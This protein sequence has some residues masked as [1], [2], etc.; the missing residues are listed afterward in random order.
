MVFLLAVYKGYE[1]KQWV[2]NGREYKKDFMRCYRWQAKSLEDL[3]G[4]NKRDSRSRRFTGPLYT[5]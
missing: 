5:I 1:G 4:F 3:H 2:I